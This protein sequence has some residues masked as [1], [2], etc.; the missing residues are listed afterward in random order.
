LIGS[1]GLMLEKSFGYAIDKADL[2]LRLGYYILCSSFQSSILYCNK[3]RLVVVWIDNAPID[4]WQTFV[5]SK[6]DVIVANDEQK[7]SNS[8]ENDVLW[9]APGVTR[10]FWQR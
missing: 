5:G 10:Q 3:P 7:W 6:T 8:S 1:S 9:I 2:V 4:G